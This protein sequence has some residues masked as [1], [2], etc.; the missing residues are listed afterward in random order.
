MASAGPA[1]AKRLAPLAGLVL[2]AILL[3]VVRRRRG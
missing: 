2:L 3:I 1:V